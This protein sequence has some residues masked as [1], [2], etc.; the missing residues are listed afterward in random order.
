MHKIELPLLK[1]KTFGKHCFYYERLGSTNDFAKD[2]GDL[3]R[4]ALIIAGEQFKGRGRLGRSWSASAVGEALSMSL[5]IRGFDPLKN[6]SL[7]LCCGLGVSKALNKLGVGEFKL[8]WPNDII[9]GG[10]KL[11][12]ILCESF[13]EKEF[14]AV[15]GI[16][17]NLNQPAEFFER[18]GLFSAASLRSISGKTFDMFEIAA[19][20]LNE[21]EPLWDKM[22]EAGFE[23]LLDEYIAG[24]DTIGRRVAFKNGSEELEGEALGVDTQGALIVKGKEKTYHV[25]SGEIL[26]GFKKRREE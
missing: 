18:A 5:V 15:C 19:L 10:R 17:I 2:H 6:G 25:T 14:S 8:K 20:A 12:G 24:C 13:F 26:T 21:I 23:S 7:P 22:K 3:E 16:G 9:C 4:G 1:T 11:C